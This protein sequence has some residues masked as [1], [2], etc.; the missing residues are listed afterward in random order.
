MTLN[1]ADS[2]DALRWARLQREALALEVVLSDAHSVER[3]EPV[4]PNRR[5][6]CRPCAG[7][8]ANIELPRG[9][10]LLERAVHFVEV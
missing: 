8:R 9:P 4:I 5:R 10:D 1:F 2:V 7:A 3:A 6:A